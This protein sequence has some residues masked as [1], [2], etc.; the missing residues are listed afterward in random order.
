M[1]EFEIVKAIG[2]YNPG[3][4]ISLST[5]IST[6][7]GTLIDYDDD[8]IFVESDEDKEV[9]TLKYSDIEDV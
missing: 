1:Y 7:K 8:F 9:V 5:N 6:I 2:Q 4:E 3:E